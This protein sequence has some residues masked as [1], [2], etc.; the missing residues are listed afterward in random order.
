[1]NHMLSHLNQTGSPR[2]DIAVNKVDWEFSKSSYQNAE[3]KNILLIAIPRFK[4]RK[5]SRLKILK[6]EK[7]I[8]EADEKFIRKLTFL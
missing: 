5:F 7:R 4:S 6:K 2:S 3:E 8:V 1:M